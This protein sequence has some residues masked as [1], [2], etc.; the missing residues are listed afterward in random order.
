[1]VHGPYVRKHKLRVVL[2]AIRIT[3]HPFEAYMLTRLWGVKLIKGRDVHRAL[4]CCL[5]P[6]ADGHAEGQCLWP[7]RPPQLLAEH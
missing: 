4:V 5:V 6:L 1:M 3:G 7:L 2:T